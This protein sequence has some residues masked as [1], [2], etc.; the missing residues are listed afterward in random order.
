MQMTISL[1][2]SITPHGNY[3]N[4]SFQK[5]DLLKGHNMILVGL[6]KFWLPVATKRR[7]Q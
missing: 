4:E 1:F 2:I 3:Q 7:L 6:C 5:F